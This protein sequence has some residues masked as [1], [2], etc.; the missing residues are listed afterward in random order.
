MKIYSGLVCY[1]LEKLHN[2]L[3]AND[4]VFDKDFSKVTFFANEMGILGVD[5]DKINLN[6][7]NNFYE[8][9]P[10]TII[11]VRLLVWHNKFEKRKEKKR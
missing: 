4:D 6:N 8:D 2:C 7:H 11:H 10:D 5:L 9:N 1:K 3:N